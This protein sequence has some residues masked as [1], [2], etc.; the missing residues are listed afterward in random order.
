MQIVQIG[1]QVSQIQLLLQLCL[2]KR[3]VKNCNRM[4]RFLYHNLKK[5]WRK[6]NVSSHRY[7]LIYI[8]GYEDMVWTSMLLLKNKQGFQ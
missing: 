7:N 2:M 1:C 5:P 8:S 6:Q 3:A 4:G